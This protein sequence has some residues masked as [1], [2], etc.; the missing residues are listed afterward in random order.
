MAIFIS[1]SFNGSGKFF[2]FDAEQFSVQVAQQITE[3]LRSR[4]D[5]KHC[6]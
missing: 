2:R 3:Q 1:I 6:N 4:K 5:N